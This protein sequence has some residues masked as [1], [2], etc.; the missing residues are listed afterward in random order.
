MMKRRMQFKKLKNNQTY[1]QE[2]MKEGKLTLKIMK[3]IPRQLLALPV[4][5]GRVILDP[6]NQR[7]ER[8]SMIFKTIAQAR[9]SDNPVQTY[10]QLA[11]VQS[12][13]V[14]DQVTDAALHP[15][16]TV[17]EWVGV[18]NVGFIEEL[19]SKKQQKKSYSKFSIPR[20]GRTIKRG[21]KR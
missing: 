1:I 19:V 5:F 18:E 17:K 15:L 9:K 4:D 11:G 2:W 16:E 21:V 12:K 20:S 14:Y 10:L 3:K 13:F 6:K 7:L 8:K